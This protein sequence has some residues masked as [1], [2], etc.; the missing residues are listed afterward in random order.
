MKESIAGKEVFPAV[1]ITQ[2]FLV[3]VQKKLNKIK[4][5]VCY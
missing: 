2:M 5:E 3:T 4:I 1:N